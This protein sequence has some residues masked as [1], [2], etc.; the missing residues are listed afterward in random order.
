[1]KLT[2]ALMI[3]PFLLASCAAQKAAVESAACGPQSP[4]DISVAGGKNELPVPGGETPNLCNI[5]F[6]RPFEHAGFV[7]PAG[8]E[9]TEA[10]VC[11]DV[12][13]GDK[14]EAHWVYTSCPL[15]AE[16]KHGLANCVCDRPDM[17]LRV[18]AGV[19]IVNDE[20]GEFTQPT[21]NLAKF[22]GSTTGTKYTNEVCSPARVNWEVSREVTYL[23]R[24]A[25]GAFCSD[26][27]YN[28]DHPHGVRELVVREDWLSPYTP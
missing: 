12:K 13:N 11:H 26:N 2:R 20:G 15:P 1:M 3:T 24:D 23:K 4:R 27:P 10:A 21:E 7:M 6:H 14:I 9:P 5:H 22:A 16:P 19:Y 8:V 18:I 25:L 28:E 17:V